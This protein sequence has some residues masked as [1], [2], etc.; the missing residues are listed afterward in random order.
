MIYG[1]NARGERAMAPLKSVLSVSMRIVIGYMI[2]NLIA[3]LVLFLIGALV[4]IGDPPIESRTL[5]GDLANQAGYI[6]VFAALSAIFAAPIALPA[7][8]VSELK[9]I[10]ALWYFLVAGAFA[11][12]PVLFTGNDRGVAEILEGFAIFGPT[13]ALASAA[14][15]LIRHRK[16]PL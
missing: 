1:D 3:S 14:F 2:A 15:W 8:A 13:G 6:P 11:A 12:V 10:D 9:K 5:L 4:S 16:W 7:I